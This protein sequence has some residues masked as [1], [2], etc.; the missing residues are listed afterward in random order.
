MSKKFT[1]PGKIIYE[2]FNPL[3]CKI[4][5]TLVQDLLILNLVR[6]S[7][8]LVFSHNYNKYSIIGKSFSTGLQEFPLR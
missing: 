1:C 7:T 5:K 4:K 8:K 3:E 6:Q 2:R